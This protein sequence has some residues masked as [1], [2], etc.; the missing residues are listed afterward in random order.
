MFLKSMRKSIKRRIINQMKMIA[1]SSAPS[2]RA[3]SESSSW[4]NDVRGDTRQSG[5]DC[6]SAKFVNCDWETRPNLEHMNSFTRELSRIKRLRAM[7][8]TRALHTEQALRNT[9]EGTTPESF[10][11]HVTNVM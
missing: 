4:P 3:G 9:S 1:F 5:W 2:V 11:L 8:A 10:D 7:F 6:T